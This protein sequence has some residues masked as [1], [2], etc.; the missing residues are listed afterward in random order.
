VTP[1]VSGSAT[2]TLSP[3]PVDTATLSATRTLT[4]SP[5]DS[6]T[7]TPSATP[8]ETQ[9][10]VPPVFSATSTPDLGDGS[11]S[12]VIDGA[13][14][15]PVPILPGGNPP[16]LFWKLN[17]PADRFAWKLFSRG[18]TAC[19][20]QDQAGSYHSGWNQLSLELPADLA[21]GGY[22]LEL[23][24]FKDSLK[25]EPKVVKLMLLR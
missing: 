11:G 25:S 18:W 21:S 19:A 12:L 4:P 15:M 1:T 23:R 8:T 5:A 2:L 9:V 6:A 13:Q 14:V 22:F 10:P 7:V 24:A 16:K 20:A 3:S 17:G